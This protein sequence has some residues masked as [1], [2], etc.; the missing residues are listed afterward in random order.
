MLFFLDLIVVLILFLIAMRGMLTAFRTRVV[1]SSDIICGVL[2]VFYGLP[3]VYDWFSTGMWIPGWFYTAWDSRRTRIIYDI[4]LLSGVLLVKLGAHRR[5]AK[6]IAGFKEKSFSLV[7]MQ[8]A[9]VV[10]ALI[11]LSWV[12]LLLPFPVALLL[13]RDPI[14][15]FTYGGLIQGR[16]Y[17]TPFQAASVALVGLTCTIALLAFF[18]IYWARMRQVRSFFDPVSLLALLLACSSVYLHAKRSVIL[19]LLIIIGAVNFL[20]RRLKL[21]TVVIGAVLL[22]IGGYSYI[23][24]VRGKEIS[25][26]GYLRGDMSR[27]YTL[28]H[29][30]YRSTWTKSGIVPYR[31]S[32][33]AFTILAYVPRVYW[34]NKPWPAPVYLTNNVFNRSVRGR[35]SLM[36]WGFGLGFMEELIMNFGYIGILGCFFVGRFSRW[37]DRFIYSRSS[38]YAILWLPMI[39]GCA[40]ASSVI[41]KLITFMVIPSF[42]FARIFAGPNSWIPLYTDDDYEYHE[43]DEA[44]D[45][46][47]VYEYSHS[48][49]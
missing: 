36:G 49:N 18:F 7:P 37:L 46:Y 8:P 39:L 14:A 12:I 22:M 43:M 1:R 17:F 45:Q 41:L 44:Y 35:T 29:V 27:D 23:G 33:Y 42:V 5:S 3:L 9:G 48:D 4:V 2:F 25:F 21:R 32:T 28:R 47:E 38:Y 24:I 16:E 11:S 34:P 26:L 30:I 19:Y 20:E 6:Q 40:F 31:G 10:R 13:I 15:V